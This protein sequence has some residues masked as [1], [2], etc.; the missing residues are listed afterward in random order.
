MIGE[1]ETYL[2]K[3]A[4]PTPRGARISQT[5]TSCLVLFASCL[6]MAAPAHAFKIVEPAEGATL[7]AGSTVT[8]QVD[9]GKDRGIVTV[10]Y[11]WYGGQDEALVEQDDTTA[12][13]SIVAPVASIGL[14]E[15]NPPFGGRLLIPKD[16]IGPMRLLAVAEIS[17][18]RLGTRSVF[19]EVMVQVE[20]KA[21]LTTIDFAT[22]KPVQLG[23]AGQ[24]SAF[25]HVDSLGK[26]FEL[27]V[28]GEFADGIVRRISAPE[29]GTTYESSSPNVIRVL[30]GGLL[31]IVGN[32]KAVL[33]VT[34]RGKQALLDVDVNVNDEPN[35]PP[36]ADAGTNK[37]VKAGSK[38]KLNGLKSRDP[39][40]EALYY[41]WSQLRGN[42]VSLLDANN[43][44]AS[45]L[46]PTV[47]EPRTYRFKLRVTDKKG[48]DSL[49][50][51]VNV[52]VEP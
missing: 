50:A 37:T 24:S 14:A 41:T 16:G 5:R 34:N 45:F 36:I 10:R 12:T 6:A 42:K 29:T 18:G 35:E 2:V 47:S 13:G 19:D 20:P 27:P 11:Y 1:R 32:G 21:A 52:T 44:E 30:S 40:G 33:T 25:G 7:T 4:S 23:R 43:A 26:I 28:V 38:V 3:P 39:E 49:P 46:A 51:F 8:A 31:Q 9:V 48:A 22:D 17:R 15:H